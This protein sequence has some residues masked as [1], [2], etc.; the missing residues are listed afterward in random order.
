MPEEQPNAQLAPG[1]PASAPAPLSAD[2]RRAQ[3]ERERAARLDDGA[4]PKPPGRDCEGCGKNWPVH[5]TKRVSY[6]EGRKQ[7]EK[8]VCFICDQNGGYK[9]A[10]IAKFTVRGA[11]L[12]TTKLFIWFAVALTVIASLLFWKFHNDNVNEKVDWIAE[13]WIQKPVEKWPALV[14]DWDARVRGPSEPVTGNAFLLERRDGSVVA[15]STLPANW[16]SA[17]QVKAAKFSELNGKVVSTLR[18]AGKPELK[19]GDF[20]RPNESPNNGIWV[21]S[22]ATPRDQLPA[23]P[24]K[25]RRQTFT[26][27]AVGTLACLA[28]GKQLS[29]PCRIIQGTTGADEFTLQVDAPIKAASVPG[30]LFLDEFGHIM[31]IGAELLP[32]NPARPGQRVLVKN[33]LTLKGVEK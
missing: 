26:L 32:P 33:A 10:E 27:G 25:V 18:V 1:H 3:A 14:A 29:Y 5:M 11:N 8:W 23:T 15:I 19:L 12:D 30:S 31:A 6:R 28:G 17:H 4:A 16:L 21:M 2:E 7:V 20:F 22:C 24:L 9:E 13:D